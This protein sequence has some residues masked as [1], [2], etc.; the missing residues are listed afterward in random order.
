MRR[1]TRLGYEIWRGEDL[2]GAVMKRLV[3][4][5]ASGEMKRNKI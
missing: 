3:S 1:S 5:K 2:A 4:L